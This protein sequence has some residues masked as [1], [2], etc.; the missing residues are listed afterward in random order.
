[1]PDDGQKYLLRGFVPSSTTFDLLCNFLPCEL[2]RL[3]FFWLWCDAVAVMAA[4]SHGQGI[5]EAWRGRNKIWSW[6]ARGD[7]LY[8]SFGLVPFTECRLLWVAAKHESMGKSKATIES[9]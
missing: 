8:T 1:M 7:Y 9:C 6:A 4:K 3:N 5:R 2:R